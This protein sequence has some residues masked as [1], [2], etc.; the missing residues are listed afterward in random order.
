MAIIINGTGS[1]SGL[2]AG[3][4][5][6]ASVTQSDLASG[7]AGTGPAFSA[8]LASNSSTISD[9]TWVKI[10]LN[11]E[12][13][14]TNNN[15]DS[16]SNYRFT[17]TV[18]GYYQIT[19]SIQ[20]DDTGNPVNDIRTAIYKNGSIHRIAMGHV[21]SGDLWGTASISALIYM[22]GSTDYLELYGLVYNGGGSAYIVGFSASKGTWMSGH[23][24]RAA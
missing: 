3:G 8:Y 20:F 22:N 15:F 19:A 16:S 21:T 10:S 7:V 6:D 18:A 24:V 13:F 11:T 4:L 9:A 14:D 12:E 1:I 23:L 5:P 2:S 17:P